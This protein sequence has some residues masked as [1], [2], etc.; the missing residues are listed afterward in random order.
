MDEKNRVSPD[1]VYGFLKEF[2][3]DISVKDLKPLVL[4]GG[5]GNL[6]F[7]YKDNSV[8]KV[9]KS[10]R[11]AVLKEARLLEYLS[12]QS[13]PVV[14]P[15]PLLVHDKG[16]YVLFSRVDGQ[17][18]WEEEEENR[19]QLAI[20]K[21]KSAVQPLAAFLTFL[22]DH[23]FPPQILEHIPRAEDSFESSYDLSKQR[24]KSLVAQGPSPRFHLSAAQLRRKLDQL[25]D[26]VAQKWTVTH[27]DLSLNHLLSVHGNA[28]SLAVIDFAD[29]VMHDP[30][31]DFAALASEL[32]EDLPTDGLVVEKILEMILHHYE[33]D[34]QRL[35]DKIEFWFLTF[36]IAGFYQKARNL[37]DS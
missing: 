21:L 4:D 34:D 20:E 32:R 1:N 5:G 16:F 29:S 12:K 8:L 6:L 30:S 25:R 22:H 37:T 9:P 14:V 31:M 17:S 18:F 13:L 23:Q 28:S 36:E 11:V 26:S 15:E 19:E 2:A 33:T 10:N 35:A 24:L 3:E 27:C 7:E